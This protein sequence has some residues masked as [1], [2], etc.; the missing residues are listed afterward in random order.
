MGLAESE[1]VR[2]RKSNL[3]VQVHDLRG[4]PRGCCCSS[5]EVGV[6]FRAVP[7][8]DGQDGIRE[9]IIPPVISVG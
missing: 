1:N 3:P 2:Q 7:L 6:R 4:I 5:S 8:R 9:H